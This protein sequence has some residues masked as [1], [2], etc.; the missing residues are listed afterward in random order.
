MKRGEKIKVYFSMNNR[1]YKLFNVIQIGKTGSVDLKITDFYPHFIIQ[2]NKV[3]SDKGFLE[4]GELENSSFIQKAEMSYHKDGSCLYKNKDII[5]AQYNNPYGKGE[6]WTRTD[7]IT[8]FQPIMHIAIRRM[9]IYSKSCVS[10][11]DKSKERIYICNN[12][13]L[14]GKDGTYLVILYLRNKKTTVNCFTTPKVYSDIIAKLSEELDLCI[15]IQRHH[16]PKPVPYYSKIFDCIVN[17]YPVNN[18]G[19]CNKEETKDEIMTCLRNNVFSLEL[20]RYLLSLSNNRFYTFTKEMID[21]MDK[22]EE[23][24]K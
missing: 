10:P 21:E 2:S 8:D 17:P 6:R 7:T 20:N 23:G 15:F 5:P 9:A 16:F 22:G 12:D 3:D 13:E 18:I 1:C 4:E 11:T 14:F 19:F 24:I